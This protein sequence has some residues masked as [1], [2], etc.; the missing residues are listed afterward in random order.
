MTV[1]WPLPAQFHP[2]S[3]WASELTHS[4]LINHLHLFVCLQ[5]LRSLACKSLQDQTLGYISSLLL[6][7]SPVISASVNW[8]PDH[9]SYSLSHQLWAPERGVLIFLTDLWIPGFTVPTLLALDSFLNMV[10]GIL[11]HFTIVAHPLDSSPGLH[12]TTASIWPLTG[13]EA[14]SAPLRS[15]KDHLPGCRKWR[16]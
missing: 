4:L 8:D 14:E 12:G 5:G 15:L 2:P 9:C 10:P 13:K 6:A 1:H 16:R 7:P 11:R 3:P